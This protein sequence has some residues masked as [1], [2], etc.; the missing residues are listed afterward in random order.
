MDQLENWIESFNFSKAE[1]DF[2]KKP[3]QEKEETE[4]F[5]EAEIRLKSFLP[6]STNKILSV[7]DNATSIIQNLFNKYV[8]DDTLVISTQHEHPSVK[9]CLARCKNVCYI[10]QNN[11]LVYNE[12][13]FKYKKVFVYV[14]GLNSGDAYFMSIRFLKELKQKFLQREIN[15]IFVLDAVQELFFIPRDYSIFDYVIGT[16]HALITNYNMGICFGKDKIANQYSNLVMDF[17]D[18]LEIIFKRKLLLFYFSSI[19]KDY[20]YKYICEDFNLTQISNVGYMYILQD[21]L[22]RFI[23]I[24]EDNVHNLDNTPL[25]FRACP[26]ISNPKISLQ[27]IK[28]TEQRLQILC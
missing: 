23:G 21:K 7:A 10:V 18:R 17:C 20:F 13:L 12:G 3:M 25:V 27:E 11:R 24:Q 22:N 26:F 19:M 4:N 2:L 8:D 28:S 6:I 14:L 1:M 16:A 9:E 15:F 5:K